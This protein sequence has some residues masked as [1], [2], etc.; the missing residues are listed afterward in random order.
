MSIHSERLNPVGQA[1]QGVLA[2]VLINA[3]L[4]PLSTIKNCLMAGRPPV[5]R[6]IYNGYQAACALDGATFATAYVT[7]DTLQSRFSSLTASVVTGTIATLGVAPAEA[8]MANR[9]VHSL[10]YSQI[11]K[12]ALRPT[13]FVIT[14][15]REIPFTSGVFWL[16]PMLQRRLQEQLPQGGHANSTPAF[17]SGAIAGSVVGAFTTPIDGIKTRVQTSDKT[18]SIF[19]AVRSMISEGGWRALF[20][21]GAT[22]AAYIG[23]TGAGM[24]MISNGAPHYFPKFLKE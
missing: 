2:S 16:A 13:G 7:N 12:R 4:H 21:G 10:P 5:L 15:C 8:L 3:A 11:W 23:L 6:G 18:L 17:V 9:Q 19:N 14:L 24:N 1:V 20:R 22:R